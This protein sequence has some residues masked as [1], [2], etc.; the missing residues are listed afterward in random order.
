MPEDTKNLSARILIVDDLADN[1]EL[2]EMMLMAA[3]YTNITSTTDP[4]QVLDLYRKW[5]YDLILLDLRMPVMDGF[6]IMEALTSAIKND[7]LPILVLT[8]ERETDVRQRALESG[9][10]DFLSKPFDNTEVLNRIANMLDVRAHFNDRRW[11]TEIVEAEVRRR[12]EELQ[13]TRLEVIR[14]LGR[15]AEYRDNETGMHVIRMSK[16]C[17]RLALAAGLGDEHATIILNASPMHDVGKIGVPDKVLLKPGPLDDEEWK[18]MRSHTEMGA[19]IIG[20]HDSDLM[21]MARLIALTHH[22]KWDGSGYPKG[23]QGT[24][25]PIE[26]RICAV[27]DVFDALTSVRPYKKA[28]TVDEA[29]KLINEEAGKHFDPDLI[30]LFNEVLP[31]LQEIRDQFADENQ[32]TAA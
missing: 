14:R 22:E 26:G 27:S 20:G 5:R 10:K 4:T 2:L 17:E 31:E 29:V 23:L 12:T 13:E 24:D 9:A 11:Q 8:A 3:G 32:V 18:I 1:V 19:D 21:R 16:Y 6:A 25:I 7:Y 30:G 15:A 28:W